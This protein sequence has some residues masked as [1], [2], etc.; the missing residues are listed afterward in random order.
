M[1]CWVLVHEKKINDHIKEIQD[2]ETIESKKTADL[3]RERL[4]KQQN[5]GTRKA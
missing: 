4:T 3:L 1:D 5:G 2:Q